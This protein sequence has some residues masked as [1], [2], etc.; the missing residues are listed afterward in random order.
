MTTNHK[1][2]QSALYRI[3]LCRNW[4]TLDVSNT[5]RGCQT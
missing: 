5:D 3:A 4:T 1:I 2:G